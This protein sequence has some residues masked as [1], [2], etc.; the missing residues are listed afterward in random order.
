[1]KIS[2]EL[3]ASVIAISI[4]LAA[5]W[6]Y[7]FL[8]GKNI[9]KAN[10]DYYAVF[11]RIDGIVESGNVFVKGYKIGNINS[12]TYDHRG[13]GNFIVKMN[14]EDGVKIPAGSK[15]LVRTSNLIASAKDLELVFKDT[16]AF[17]MPGDTLTS[18]VNPGLSELLDPITNKIDVVLLDLDSTLS[19]I[20]DV[21]STGVKDDLKAS[22]GNLNSI[23]TSLKSD[24]GP[25]GDLD[26]S[27]KNLRN[28]T[29][30]LS[31]KSADIE[32]IIDNVNNI[33]DSL[34]HA[35]LKTTI[36]SFDATLKQ[37]DKLISQMTEGEGTMNKLLNDSLLYVELTNTIVSLDSLL[38]DLK[39]NPN[40]YVHISVFGGKDKKK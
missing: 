24:L 31:E 33:T 16:N 26:K 18:G 17:L 8:K 4:I 12:V 13:T 1:M 21:F 10:N 30:T 39:E 37:A 6:G 36:Q 29:N 9:L 7:S 2:T 35:N 25:G 32:S 15:V 40:R 19:H 20:N 3:K 5:I 34:N 27:F 38:V 11:K 22:L 28:L 23:T 14:V